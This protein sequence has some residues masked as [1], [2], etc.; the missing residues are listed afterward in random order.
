MRWG[1][2]ALAAAVIAAVCHCAAEARPLGFRDPDTTFPALLSQT[3]VFSDL[4]AQQ[5]APELLPYDLNH[6]FWSDGATKRRWI[7]LPP[8]EKIVYR[9]DEP[10]SFRQQTLFV[11]HFEFPAAEEGTTIPM[12]T[13]LL[14]WHGEGDVE[15]V[16]YRW[17]ADGKEADMVTESIVATLPP[18]VYAHGQDA[19]ATVRVTAPAGQNQ[20]RNRST[21]IL[22]VHPGAAAANSWYF[23]GPND[24]RTCHT[25]VGGGVLGVNTR[26]LNRPLPGGESQLVHLAR[27]GVLD[28]FSSTSPLADLPGLAALDDESASLERRA[29]S[30]ID[31]NCA[32]C[33]AGS[34][35]AGYFDARFHT[36]A[37]AQNIINGRVMINFGI[38]RARVVAPNDPWRS[39]LLRRMNTLD[40]GV[41]MP[42][43]G[44]TRIDKK[45]VDLM[46]RWILSMPGPNAVAPPEIA[47]ADNRVTITHREPDVAIRYT[48]DGSAPSG[49]SS[50]YTTP[51]ILNQP[52]T[53][54][55]R[56]FRGEGRSIVV[57]ETFSLNK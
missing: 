24:C 43:L 42:P 56:A 35:S 55:A 44:H 15:G 36:P 40:S 12:E 41:A 23:P 3:G 2:P 39:L 50:V 30:Y 29:R 11:K 31:V 22:P 49:S 28:G 45:G 51:I 19:R 1:A 57:H 13:R 25:A 48:T 6:P 14:L 53:I 8:G 4:A 10:W 34:G 18:G 9:R 5:P 26:Q 7:V 16:T 52:T 32:M 27:L 17:R 46:R 21:G 38:D 37:T 33:H 47:I 54:R 20:G